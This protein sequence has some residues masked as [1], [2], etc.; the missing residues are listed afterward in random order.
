MRLIEKGFNLVDVNKLAVKEAGYK[1]GK[2][3]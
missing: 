1:A 3:R 2:A